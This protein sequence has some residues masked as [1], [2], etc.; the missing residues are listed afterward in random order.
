MVVAGLYI[1]VCPH[2][3]VCVCVCSN[4]SESK[5]RRADPAAD[6]SKANKR[7]KRSKMGGKVHFGKGKPRKLGKRKQ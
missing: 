1:S 3:V 7:P 5:K 6:G 4:F 2:E